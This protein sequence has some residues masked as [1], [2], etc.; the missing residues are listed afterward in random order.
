MSQITTPRTYEGHELETIF[1]RP[2]LH[3]ANAG[4]LGI[5]V[6]YNVP[7]PTIVT[8]WKGASNVLQKY[9]NGWSGGSPSD[10]FQKKIELHKVKSELG[11]NATD[12]QT[13]IYEKAVAHPDVNFDD[14]SGTELELAETLVFR[15]ALAESIRATMWVGRRDRESGLLDTFD[16]FLTQLLTDNQGQPQINFA[17]ISSSEWDS[18]DA[19]ET[20]LKKVWDRATP[21]LRERKSHGDLAYFVTSDVYSKY[22]ESL[23]NSSLEAA[24]L[25]RQNGRESL[26]F[27]GIPV[28]DIQISQYINQISDLPKTW[29]VLADRKNFA[30]AVNT[31]DFPGSEIRLWYNADEMENRQ[32]AVFAAGCDYLLPELVC[33]GYKS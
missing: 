22:E 20:L 5:R 11:F 29:I 32:R 10:K 6:L 18:V 4:E 19:G 7:V 8:F 23:D 33:F 1:F 30:M 25:A 13:M 16:G 21:Q 9:S 24:Y 28:I 3:G 26:S 27:R 12:Y 14:L 31:R 2:M 17:G 15:D